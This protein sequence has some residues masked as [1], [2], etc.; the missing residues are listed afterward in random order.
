MDNQGTEHINAKAPLI[1][2]HEH[3]SNNDAVQ[4]SLSFPCFSVSLFLSLFSFSVSLSFSCVYLRVLDVCSSFLF[5]ASKVNHSCNWCLHCCQ[6]FQHK[7]TRTHIN[8]RTPPLA[9]NNG[10]I[11]GS[12][13]R[14]YAYEANALPTE[15]RRPMR[16]ACISNTMGRAGGPHVSARCVE[17][18]KSCKSCKSCKNKYHIYNFYNFYRFP[19]CKSCK[20]C[21]SCKI[22]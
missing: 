6:T 22:Y 12:S 9:N 18:C 15:L 5:R 21:K 16:S 13:H 10:P 17:A 11:W 4:H 3:N 20:S 1:L 8:A 2:G 14:P 7:H 19:N